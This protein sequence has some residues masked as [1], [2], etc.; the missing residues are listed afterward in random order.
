[1]FGLTG[2]EI[3]VVVFIVCAVVSAPYWP[4]VGEMIALA[5]VRK[6]EPSRGREP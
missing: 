6:K 5:L 3:F 1:M 4:R 2:G